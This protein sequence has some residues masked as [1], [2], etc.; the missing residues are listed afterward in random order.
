MARRGNNDR[1]AALIRRL[2][3]IGAAVLVRDLG[4]DKAKAEASMREIAHDLAKEHG[5]AYIYVPQDHE[6]ELTKRDM[7]IWDRFNGHNV[8]ELVAEFGLSQVQI[9]CIIKHVR[10]Q[11]ARRNQAALPGFEDGQQP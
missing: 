6:F 2:T 5:G 8:Q 3:E 9:H 10:R 4:V 7:R 1:A 11:Q